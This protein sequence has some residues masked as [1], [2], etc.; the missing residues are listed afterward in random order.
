MSIYEKI[1]LAMVGNRIHIKKLIQW[2][3][4][5]PIKYY[6]FDILN[7]NILKNINKNDYLELQ[8]INDNL[9]EAF[10]II[11]FKEINKILEENYILYNAA[12]ANLGYDKY[13]D[14]FINNKKYLYS[15]ILVSAILDKGRHKD[16]DLFINH[17]EWFIVNL[18]VKQQREEDLIKL[19]KSGNKDISWL[20]NKE[21]NEIEFT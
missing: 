7:Y 9:K 14:C 5:Q 17:K 19:S 15:E 21:L 2:V 3:K 4:N 12:I 10:K 11:G 1:A 8:P 6:N 16:L 18:I 20:A 13:L